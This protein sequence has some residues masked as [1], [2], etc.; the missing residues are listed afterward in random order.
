MDILT[1]HIAT[2]SGNTEPPAGWDDLLSKDYFKRQTTASL[3]IP[4]QDVWMEVLN[5]FFSM[6]VWCITI[7]YRNYTQTQN[8]KSWNALLKSKIRKWDITV[9]YNDPTM[10][11]F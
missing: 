8:W 7:I 3:V 11:N 4:N 2:F 10:T 5:F 9:C 6:R 1:I